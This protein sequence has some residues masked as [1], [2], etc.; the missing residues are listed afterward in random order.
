MQPGTAR[1]RWWLALLVGLALAA[2]PTKV[3]AAPEDAPPDGFTWEELK[4]IRTWVLRPEGWF[5]R[6]I[7]PA[8][9]FF[10]FSAVPFDG[11]F[12]I[13]KGLAIH[14]MAGM[15]QPADEKA[16]AWIA[17]CAAQYKVLRGWTRKGVPAEP[18]T[19][20][21]IVCTMQDEGT[22]GVR[23]T[24]EV[25]LIANHVTNTVYQCWLAAP[26]AEW[27]EVEA[28]GE[29]MLANLRLDPGF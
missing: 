2:C 1:A 5:F 27:K 24:C 8:S 10:H 20:Y 7:I 19:S 29:T 18:F 17:S 11:P 26:P 13:K 16:A 12:G 15:S 21:G 6:R 14:V 23:Y 22:D 9:P 4:E 3:P 28:K 25:V